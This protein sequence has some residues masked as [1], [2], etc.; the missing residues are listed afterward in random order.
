MGGDL[1]VL[2]LMGAPDHHGVVVPN[3]C[4]PVLRLAA[5]CVWTLPVASAHA[6]LSDS[7]Y[8]MVLSFVC[9]SYNEWVARHGGASEALREACRCAAV[10]AAAAR[11][12]LALRW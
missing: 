3:G 12:C 6:A 9:R 11:A 5:V 1:F 2:V 4:C 10:A 7:E 8:H